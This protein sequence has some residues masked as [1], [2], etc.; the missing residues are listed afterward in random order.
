LD[1]LVD[2]WSGSIEVGITTHNP[3]TLDIP[4]TMTNMRSGMYNNTQPRYS[5]LSSAYKH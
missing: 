5:E 4:A 1:V 3:G 2:K